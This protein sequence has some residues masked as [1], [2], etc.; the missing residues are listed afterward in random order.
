MSKAAAA[1]QL[2]NVFLESMIK[3][4]AAK[5]LPMAMD[6]KGYF[7]TGVVELD[8]T[9]GK[10][11]VDVP[12]GVL[13]SVAT[14]IVELVASEGTAANQPTFMLIAVGPKYCTVLIHV[15]ADNPLSPLEWAQACNV[16]AI[17]TCG[18]CIGGRVVAE[19]PIKAKDTIIGCA[20]AYLRKHGLI[21]DEDSDDEG[22]KFNIN[23]DF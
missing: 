11:P 13:N 3:A 5:I 10:Q 14:N 9:H 2:V 16:D 15:S 1:D 20:C 23:D 21:K 18:Q 6:S 4:Q 8:G 12:L 19:Y 17:E 7:T 22:P